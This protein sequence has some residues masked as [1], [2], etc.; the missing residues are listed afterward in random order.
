MPQKIQQIVKTGKP[1]NINLLLTERE[2]R[3]GEYWHV[4]VAVRIE[5]SEA[6]TNTIE[7]NILQYGSS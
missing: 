3:T 7:G 1:L 2:D 6:H 5:L 4:V